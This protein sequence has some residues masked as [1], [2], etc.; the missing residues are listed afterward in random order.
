MAVPVKV[1]YAALLALV[2]LP[3]PA[4]A[5]LVSPGRLSSAHA[6]LEG[7]RQCTACHRLRRPGVDDGLCLDCHEPLRDRIAAGS[8]YHAGLRGESCATCHKEHVGRDVRPMRW[9]PS[10]FRHEQAGFELRG[11]HA[12]AE[13]D[14]CHRPAL[15][16]AADVRAWQGHE[17]WLARTYLG[18]PTS[19]TGCHAPEDPHAGQ[20]DGRGCGE[21]HDESS[22]DQAPRFDHQRAAFRLTG[23]H[24]EVDCAD[25]H[26]AAPE[27]PRVVRFASL[28]AEGC[29]SCHVD[30]HRGA[31]GATC[32]SCHAT[33]G[34]GALTS[35][36]L[37]RFDHD[38][39]RFRL[40]GAHAAVS[41]ES[42]HGGARRPG[43]A[44]RFP[45]GRAG[46]TYPRPE[47]SRCRSCHVDPHEPAARVVAARDC[48]ACHQVA[49]WSPVTAG[50]AAH[51]SLTGFALEGAHAAVP[52]GACHEPRSR[53]PARLALD[54][55]CASCHAD[56]DP[57]EGRFGRASCAECHGT[58][59]FAV[60]EFDHARAGPGGCAS[61]HRDEDPHA[62][63]F[64][65]RSCDE[66]H[67]TEIFRIADF[68]HARTRFPLD[69]AHGRV[70]CG[71]C[72][73]PGIEG[74]DGAAV[75]YR[76]LD[77]DCAS[78]HGGA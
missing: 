60:D 54:G 44:L 46:R 28:D 32:E 51:G 76:P 71:A 23:S 20:F 19:C 47:F 8:G 37:N 74:G 4:T 59:S 56:R 11:A 75:R 39:T 70:D 49:G 13:C 29:A 1:W 16:Q 52:C 43:I 69:G 12:E 7:V 14:A 34:W 10:T 36:A 9:D 73:R 63:Q 26:T 30:P 66:C 53:E 68:D 21:C 41:C 27:R 50:P 24:I 45:Q 67:V 18:L 40:A 62:R 42:C 33:E 78:C 35:R 61:C 64:G 31:M 3:A 5:Q 2:T 77:V 58:A 25:C 22:W 17:G 15:V 48:A 6:E 72:H 57:H 65:E 38:R 55:A